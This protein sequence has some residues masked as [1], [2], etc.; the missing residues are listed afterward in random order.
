VQVAADAAY[1]VVVIGSGVRRAANPTKS[2]GFLSRL[3]AAPSSSTR[4]KASS[5][6]D[7]LAVGMEFHGE[8]N[9]T[10]ELAYLR[11]N[12]MHAENAVVGSAIPILRGQRHCDRPRWA[13][14]DG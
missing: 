6:G 1:D 12:H 13:S 14:T 2:G 9:L 5:R 7:I 11:A 8:A 3:T 4:A 10:D